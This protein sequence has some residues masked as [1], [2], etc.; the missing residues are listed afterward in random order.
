MRIKE[1]SV[2]SFSSTLTFLQKIGIEMY[3]CNDVLYSQSNTLP[4]CIHA[5][6]LMS[7]LDLYKY[8]EPLCKSLRNRAYQWKYYGP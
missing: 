7:N 3:V 4:D 8:M 5:S 6:V 2:E 1:T